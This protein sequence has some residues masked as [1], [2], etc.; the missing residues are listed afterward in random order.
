MLVNNYSEALKGYTAVL[1]Q[2]PNFDALI[3]R[4]IVLHQLGRFDEAVND[5]EKAILTDRK[6]FEGFL[7]R[8]LL[9]I[10]IP[11]GHSNF[12]QGRVTAALI[13]LEDAFAKTSG[14]T[15]QYIE[16]QIRKVQA[17]LDNK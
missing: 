14:E 4:S 7:R 2:G 16:T 8:G 3:G 10:I 13:D 15:A 12:S 9:L 17:E 1:N 5:A 11:K 6:R